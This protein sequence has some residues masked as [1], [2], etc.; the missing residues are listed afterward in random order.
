MLAG[1][2]FLAILFLIYGCLSPR[3][4][5]KVIRFIFPAFLITFAFVCCAVLGVL[6]NSMANPNEARPVLEWAYKLVL[7]GF[8]QN[9]LMNTNNP[10]AIYGLAGAQLF[11]LPIDL[12]VGTLKLAFSMKFP[13]LTLMI[14][15]WMVFVG[16]VRQAIIVPAAE[17]A[18]RDEDNGVFETGESFHNEV[19]RA[20]AEKDRYDAVKAERSASLRAEQAARDAVA[21]KKQAELEAKIWPNGLN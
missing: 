15:T 12:F 5:A 19:W 10:L 7:S 11:T 16:F 3:A 20:V 14:F 17:R 6:L 13:F 4:Q 21:A 2:T 8:V 18:K 9:V 1:L